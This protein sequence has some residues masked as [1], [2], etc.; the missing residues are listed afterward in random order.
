MPSVSLFS[1][2]LSRARSLSRS[3]ARSLSLS[4]ALSFSLSFSLSR[5]LSFSLSGMAFQLLVYAVHLFHK[6]LLAH[7]CSLLA[8][9]RPLWRFFLD[10]RIVGLLYIRRAIGRRD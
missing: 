7:S 10:L 2:I 9:S 3:L 1:L 6:P 8:L 5:S 4:L